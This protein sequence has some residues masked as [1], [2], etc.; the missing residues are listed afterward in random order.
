MSASIPADPM[1]RRVLEDALHAWVMTGAALGE[2]RVIWTSGVAVE[3]T[4]PFATLTWLS[5]LR[6]GTDAEAV[7]DISPTPAVDVEDMRLTSSGLRQVVVSVAVYADPAAPPESSAITRLDSAVARLGLSVVRADLSAA[8]FG[9]LSVG[10]QRV[11]TAGHAVVDIT[12]LV[13]SSVTEDVFSI[14]TT[15]ADIIVDGVDVGDATL[16]E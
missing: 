11:V 7:V 12:A 16:P 2:E 14:E 8:G 3:T 15:Q 9:I 13:A 1:N 5:T 10:P 4:F 6:I